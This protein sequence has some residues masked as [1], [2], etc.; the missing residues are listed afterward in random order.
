MKKR[1]LLNLLIVAVATS[2]LFIANAQQYGQQPY[3]QPMQQQWQQQP[4]NWQQQ[5][6]SSPPIG[7]WRNE[8]ETNCFYWV[9]S[10]GV[11]T[12]GCRVP[13][14]TKPV[15][16]TMNYSWQPMSARQGTL[17]AFLPSLPP[18]QG[19]PQIQTPP[20]FI[21][22]I[23]WVNQNRLKVGSQSLLDGRVYW[24]NWIRSGTNGQ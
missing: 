2:T 17:T 6:L 23:E 4:N 12:S 3:G 16:G 22:Q 20:P 10:R 5:R 18:I 15:G 21:Y 11:M 7:L 13:G 8:T 1:Y 9:E 14:K 19:M 24:S